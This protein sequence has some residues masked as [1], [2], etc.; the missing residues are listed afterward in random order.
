[1]SP[2]THVKSKLPPLTP[3]GFFEGESRFEGFLQDLFGRVRR[4]YYG[5][6]FGRIEGN[7][8]HLEEHLTFTDGEKED[9]HWLFTP[10][11]KGWN[12]SAEGII[13]DAEILPIND[14]EM[15]WRYKMEITVAGRKIGFHFED[16]FIRITPSRLVAHTTMR[17]FGITWARLTSIYDQL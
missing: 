10:A 15:R 17:K 11:L 9:R 12:A 13:G 8:L 7:K 2:E 16:V 1:M 6:A 5:R 14:D 4:S 3:P